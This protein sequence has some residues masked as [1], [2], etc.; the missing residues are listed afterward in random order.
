MGTGRLT[1]RAPLGALGVALAAGLALLWSGGGVASGEE[2]D[3]VQ[4]SGAGQAGKLEATIRRTEHGIPHILADD[5]AGLGFGYG[6]AFAEDNICTIAESYVTVRAERSRYFGPDESYQQRGNGFAANNLNSDLFYQR[7]ID[8]GIIE[9]L[10]DQPSPTGPAP[11]IVEGVRGYVAGYNKYLQETGVDNLP[12]P[13]CRGAEWVRPISEID[14]YRR[15]YQLA[16]LASGTVAIDGIAGEKTPGASGLPIDP[17]DIADGLAGVLPID[18]IGSNAYGL[19]A[20]ATSNGKGIVLANPHFPWDG[21]ERF[22]QTHLTIPGEVNVS[23]AS[24]FGVPLVLIGHTDNLAWSHTVSTAYRFTPFQE[25]LNPADPTQYLYDG[26]FRDMVEDEVTV[27]V[28]TPT[29]LEPRTRTIYSTK[30]GLVFDDLVGVPLPWTPTTAFALGD[31]NATNFRYLNHFFFTNQAQ[32]VRELDQIEREYQGIPWVNT[33]A[34]DSSGEAYYADIGAIPNVSDAKASE[35]NTAVGA[36]TSAALGLPVLDGSRASCEWGTDADAVAPGIFGYENLPKLFRDDYVTNS[37]D[38]Y[39]LSNPEQPLEGFARI[40][41]DERTERALRTRIGLIMLREHFDDQ[42]QPATDPLN[43]QD[44]QNIVF[45]NRQYAAELWRDELVAFC[46][47]TP[48][49]VGSSG[50]V[51]VSEA[52]PVLENWNRR[53]DLDAPGAILFREFAALALTGV[54]VVS[55]PSVYSTP[56]DPDNPVTTPSGLNE[57]SPKIQ[58]SLADAVSNLNAAGIPL[59]GTLRD[60]QYEKRGEQRIPIHGGPGG[61]GVFNAINVNSL[62]RGAPEPGYPN[63]GH[64]SSFVMVTQFTD[65]SCGVDDRSIL[66]YSLS[67]NPESP[68]FGDQTELFSDKVWVDPPFCEAEVLA[69]DPDVTAIEGCLPE[70]C[71]EARRRGRCATAIRGTA[72]RDRLTGTALSETLTGG[73]GNDRLRGKGGRDCLK[74]QR[75]R[76]LIAGG[77][78]RDAVRGGPG[79]DRIFSRDRRTDAIFCGPGRDRVNADRRDSLF[80]CETV[81]PRDEIPPAG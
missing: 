22:Y 62:V 65:S 55:D 51:D 18:G 54:S 10:L 19:G 61:V 14:A 25:T 1:A 6:Y 26:E 12:D 13:R 33:I 80:G 78:G 34:A 3:R 29:G 74:G 52:C 66:T 43:R 71:V 27:Q 77:L 35:C 37:N 40:I 16:L 63:V 48:V 38:S 46:E 50:P 32:S 30:H 44:V 41:G 49:M 47:A 70:G 24:L 28:K 17:G 21:P 2:V 60:Y 31:V 58:Q 73:A 79:D 64:G 39:W 8:K 42:S 53:D 5:F 9:D 67:E 20:E 36:A 81:L 7:I 59:N 23:G 4:A 11:E 15:F 57:A 56:F 75:G 76:D 68:F 72:G 69:A 45:N